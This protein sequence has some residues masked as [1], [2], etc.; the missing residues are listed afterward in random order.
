M[1]IKEIREKV[2]Y[3]FCNFINDKYLR[4]EIFANESLNRLS[5]FQMEVCEI[6]FKKSQH[7]TRNKYDFERK[8]A[9]IFNGKD[10]FKNMPSTNYST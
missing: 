9:Q 3:M 4:I 10:D 1:C 6:I 2:K 7:P 5:S 8:I